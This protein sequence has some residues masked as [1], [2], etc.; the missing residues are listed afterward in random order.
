MDIRFGDWELRR[1]DPLNWTLFHL[2]PVDHGA[3]KGQVE[4]RPTYRFFQSLG[5]ALEYAYEQEL[6]G[7]EGSFTLAEALQEAR[8]I[9]DSLADAAV[10]AE[11][12]RD[13][14]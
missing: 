8:A 3:R 2:R 4:W 1:S 5:H 12:S 7:K 10:T 11:S 6:L 9:R 13:G 14:T